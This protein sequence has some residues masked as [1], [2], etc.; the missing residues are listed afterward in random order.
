MEWNGK[1]GEKL[2]GRDAAPRGVYVQ[3]DGAVGAVGLEE[4]ELRDDRGGGGLV[5]GPGQRD[6][7]LLEE[8]AENVVRV[9]GSSL[10]C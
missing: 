2:T 3:V 1:R 8:L 6:D 5:H 7:A 10:V 4:E 9:P